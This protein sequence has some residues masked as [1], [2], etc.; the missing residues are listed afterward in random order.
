M[1]T[2]ASSWLEEVVVLAA[3]RRGARDE[4]E[5]LAVLHAVIGDLGDAAVLAEI[6]GE[7][8]LVDQLSA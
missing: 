7:H 1:L 5:H 4:V 3:G 8:A 6:D 2:P